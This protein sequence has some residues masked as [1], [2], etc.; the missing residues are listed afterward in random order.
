[1]ELVSNITN[2]IKVPFEDLEI[3]AAY[4]DVTDG[5]EIFLY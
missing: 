2:N 4:F 5:D 3:G 1:M